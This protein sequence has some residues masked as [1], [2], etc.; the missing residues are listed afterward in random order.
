MLTRSLTDR[1][2]MFGS[3]IQFG[4]WF[5]KYADTDASIALE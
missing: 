3:Y 5:I 1:R 4:A 2:L